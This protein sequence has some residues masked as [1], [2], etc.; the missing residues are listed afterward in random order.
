MHV[1]SHGVTHWTVRALAKAFGIERATAHC[2]LV[3]HKV[4]SRQWWHFKVL[5]DPDFEEKDLRC[6]EVIH[7]TAGSGGGAA[8]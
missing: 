2:I 4:A 3:R 7:G 5:N 1:D 8:D 6:H